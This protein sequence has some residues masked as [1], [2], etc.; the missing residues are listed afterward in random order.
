MQCHQTLHK[1]LSSLPS[2]EVILPIRC[3][4]TIDSKTYSARL[5]GFEAIFAIAGFIIAAYYL[6]S[7]GLRGKVPKEDKYVVYFTLCI[8]FS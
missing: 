4:V 6:G 1:T 5:P 7:C 8:K 3:V 2:P